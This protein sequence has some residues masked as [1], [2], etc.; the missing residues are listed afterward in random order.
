MQFSVT[1]VKGN[2]K[3]EKYCFSCNTKK[4]VMLVKKPTSASLRK[5]M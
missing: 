2:I 1:E 3:T 4:K 5:C